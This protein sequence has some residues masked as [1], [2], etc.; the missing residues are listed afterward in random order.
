MVYEHLTKHHIQ[1]AIR[2]GY[3]T[4]MAARYYRNLQLWQ[5]FVLARLES[6]GSDWLLSKA[7]IQTAIRAS[8][9]EDNACH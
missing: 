1:V 2:S 6:G 7:N 5:Q 3:S 9:I 8:Y 4:K